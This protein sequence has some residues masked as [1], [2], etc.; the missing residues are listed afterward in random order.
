MTKE[1]ERLINGS[2][3]RDLYK[4]A[5]EYATLLDK[6]DEYYQDVID[7]AY[8]VLKSYILVKTH[9]NIKN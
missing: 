7:S 4:F 1:Q 5:R 6:E 9:E 8:N 2:A 3:L